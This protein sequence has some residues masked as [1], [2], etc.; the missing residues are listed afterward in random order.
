MDFSFLLLI[1]V[2]LYG[3]YEN[4]HMHT[5]INTCNASNMCCSFFGESD[6]VV[7]VPSD[8][9]KHFLFIFEND[10]VSTSEE[11]IAAPEIS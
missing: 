9:Q 11:G 10:A 6:V 1:S 8:V 5:D 4:T 3:I 7:R 2:L